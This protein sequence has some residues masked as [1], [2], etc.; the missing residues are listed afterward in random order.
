MRKV[1][2]MGTP[3]FACGILDT[4]INLDYVEVVGVVTQPDKKVGRKQEI[5]MTPVKQLALS[6]NIEVFQ[7][8]S[9]KTDYDKVLEWKPDVVI[10]C[11]YGQLIPEVIL[12]AFEFGCVNVHA[13]LLPKYR[14]GAPIHMAIIN[15]EKQTGIT[16][17]QMIKKMD[18]GDI[19]YQKSI[20]INEDDTTSILFDKLMVVGQE[21][22]REFLP[23]FFN[24]NY[25]RIKQDED[26]VTFA[27]NISKEMEFVSFDRDYETVVN[28]IRGLI[29]WPIGYGIIEDKKI[30]LH[31]V[32]RVNKKT[33]EANGTLL[34]LS[35]GLL[36]IACDNKVVGIATLQLEGK[37]KVSAKDF[38]NGVGRQLVGKCFK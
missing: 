2:F 5:Q 22:V 33:D 14:G 15:G 16:I 3:D 10:T 37:G 9:I 20:N 26:K 12:N 21:A 18:A 27:Y 34:G 19:F 24:N 8:I 28:H 6:H 17:M 29:S 23:D 35:D 32:K 7:P 30:K 13:S 31:D 1:V 25:T 38:F 36:E 11:A 4:L